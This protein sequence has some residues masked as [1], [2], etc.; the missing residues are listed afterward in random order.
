MAR[1]RLVNE[2]KDYP[3]D[4]S[5]LRI[6]ALATRLGIEL[7]ESPPPEYSSLTW[8]EVSNLEA[9]GVSFGGHTVRHATLSAETD[10]VAW[11]EIEECTRTLEI[12][13]PSSLKSFLLSHWSIAGLR[14]SRDYLSEGTWVPGSGLRGARILQIDNDSN[15]R[16]NLRRFSFP[17]NL[18][19][20]KDI[21]LQLQRLRQRLRP[22][23]DDGH[24][25]EHPS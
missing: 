19:D 6:E 23:K 13:S 22:W 3:L 5:R 2:L 1:R 16:F 11:R 20:F 4:Q 15:S 10:E 24:Y 21:V 7:P 25:A 18:L 17:D 9:R 8:A 12:P 14:R